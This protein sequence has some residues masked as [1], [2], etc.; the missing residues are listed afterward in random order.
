MSTKSPYH[1]FFEW[2]DEDF[3]QKNATSISRLPTPEVLAEKSEAALQGTLELIYNLGQQLDHTLQHMEHPPSQ[4]DL[5]FGVRLGA[6]SGVITKSNHPAHFTVT[7]H[8]R[9]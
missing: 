8:W 7:L 3:Y 2:D 6:D 5:T 1:I 4:C 9:P